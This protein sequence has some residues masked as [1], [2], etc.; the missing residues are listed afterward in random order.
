MCVLMRHQKIESMRTTRATVS[1]QV[2]KAKIDKQG[3]CPV[4]CV[5]CWHGERLTQSTQ[6]KVLSKLWDGK[7]QEVKPKHPNAAVING[8]LRNMRYE[9][10]GRINI[11]EQRGSYTVS[12]IIC[13]NDDD[14]YVEEY[15]GQYEN[16]L[17]KYIVDAK[18]RYGSI[19]CHRY[20]Y[21]L[22]KERFGEH[23]DLGQMTDTKLKDFA[24]WLETKKGLG[25]HSI[26]NALS[27]VSAIFN[28]G[29]ENGILNASPMKWRYS[30]TY[31]P[32][33]RLYCLTADI[34]KKVFQ[35]LPSHAVGDYTSK[36]DPIV[37]FCA[38]FTLCGIA[39][40]DLSVL[41]TEN[42]QL[43]EVEGKQY[44]RVVFRRR[45]TGAQAQM[46]LP[47]DDENVRLCFGNFLETA[48]RRNGYLYPVLRKG[49]I[50]TRVENVF[51]QQKEKLL[52]YFKEKCLDVDPEKFCFYTIRHT[53]ASIYAGHPQ[54]SLRGMATTMG[55]SVE[56]IEV[57]IKQLNADSELVAAS[58]RLV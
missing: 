39:P 47:V 2:K 32:Q 28:Y 45:K 49:R 41:R 27:R 42:V 43:A 51:C 14:Y 19:K 3:L 54:A 24:Y 30:R 53:Y 29:V 37:L 25:A 35:D 55:R 31:R 36:P 15:A 58:L 33:G 21:N 23:Y 17:E 10:D 38:M 20:G 1:F 26:K 13:F 8:T 22:F 16:L 4:M 48:E 6:C 46:M 50:E 7:R 34:V 52:R 5:I 9:L 44:Y 11:L 18:L 40:I 57:Y 12:D 56:G